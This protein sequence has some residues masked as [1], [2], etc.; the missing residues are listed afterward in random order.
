[1][2]QYFFNPLAVPYFISFLVSA[3]LMVLL[4]V[5]KR[6]DRRVQ[7]YIIFQGSLAA[8]SLMAGMASIS[9][10]IV[11][12][13][14]WERFINPVVILGI[15]CIWHFSYISLHDTDVF[16]DRRIA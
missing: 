6:K 1:M 13:D 5:K 16:E 11:T 4:I 7:L 14:K 10:D 9:D 3:A 2:S 8:I 12:W 15:I